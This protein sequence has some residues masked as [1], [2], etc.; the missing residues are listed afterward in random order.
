[1]LDRAAHPPS[2]FGGEWAALEAEARRPEPL[3]R[4]LELATY[5]SLARRVVGPGRGGWRARPRGRALADRRDDQG[6]ANARLPVKDVPE[7]TQPD[8]RD[9]A[10]ARPL[11]AAAPPRPLQA[12]GRGAAA[13]AERR[14]LRDS[15]RE[16]DGA[17]RLRR[18]RRTLQRAARRRRRTRCRSSSTGSRT[19]SRSSSSSPRRPSARRAPIRS[20]ATATGPWPCTSTRS[21]PSCSRPRRAP[22]GFVARPARPGGRRFLDRAR[23]DAARRCA[24][25]SR[26][27]GCSASPPTRSRPSSL[28]STAS[29]GRTAAMF[30]DRER[31]LSDVLGLLVLGYNSLLGAEA[32]AQLIGVATGT[33]GLLGEAQS[34]RPAVGAVGAEREEAPSTPLVDSARRDRR[35]APRGGR[36]AAGPRRD[37]RG[38]SSTTVRSRRSG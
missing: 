16:A 19:P 2:V 7:P 38:R 3:A 37:A 22:L 33:A 29:A 32:R 20:S 21:A 12:L 30:D 23:L 1:M 34:A 13:R 25:S 9:P 18:R 27:R 36:P 15:G 24:R 35:A 11:A 10:A 6:R 17:D 28:R 31:R 8:A 4:T 5:L 26:C 14:R